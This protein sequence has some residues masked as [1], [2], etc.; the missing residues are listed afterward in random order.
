MT[1]VNAYQAPD[2]HTV[3]A[4]SGILGRIAVLTIHFGLLI[5][6]VLVCG[7]LLGMFVGPEPGSGVLE[8]DLTGLADFNRSFTN[9]F[10]VPVMLVLLLD[11]PVYFLVRALRGR[12]T[13]WAWLC[14]TTALLPI[15][16]VVY[17]LMLWR[18]II[19]IPYPI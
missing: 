4:E 12:P 16:A 13:R 1:N 3:N 14:W 19:R 9:Y 10:F 17:W 6:M 8:T 18:S 7:P 15:V 11:L 5:G 2:S